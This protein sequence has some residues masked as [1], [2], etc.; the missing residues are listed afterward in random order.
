MRNSAIEVRTRIVTGKLVRRAQAL[1]C[2]KFRTIRPWDH[3]APFEKLMEQIVGKTLVDRIRCY[4]LYQYAAQV[5]SLAGDVAEVGVYKGGTARLL[6]KAFKPTQKT[7]HLFDTFAG[8][9]ATADPRRD[10]HKQ[11]DFHD[12]SL[13]TVRAYLS[14]CPNVTFYQGLFPATAT[15]VEHKTFCFVHVDA[16]IY[17]SVWDCCAFF[18]PRLER[19][20]MMIFDDYG[21][22]HCPGAKAAVD[23]FFAETPETACYL[24]TGQCVV[25]RL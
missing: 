21:E 3:D 5:T 10:R 7:I 8:M 13:E 1:M 17:R 22:K 24:P 9:P 23:Q 12:T 18:Y 15:P 4:M 2:N 20:G 11:G 25:A 14:D 19:G 6:A 16:D